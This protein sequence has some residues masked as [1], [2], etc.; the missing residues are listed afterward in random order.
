MQSPSPHRPERTCVGCRQT[1]PRAQ[2]LRLVREE[3]PDGSA[4]RVRLDP[5][6]AASGRGAWLHRDA[7]CL[8]LALR[9]GGLAR[10][11]RGRV[12]AGALTGDLQQYEPTIPWNR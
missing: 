2:L 7:S 1:A 10:S 8:D 9:R 5:T 4:P 3:T 6:G 11:F 12:D